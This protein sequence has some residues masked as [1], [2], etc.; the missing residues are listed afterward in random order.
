MGLINLLEAEK[1][2]RMYNLLDYKFVIKGY[3]SG[4]VKWKTCIGKKWVKGALRSVL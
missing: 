4:T 2:P 1:T 3:N